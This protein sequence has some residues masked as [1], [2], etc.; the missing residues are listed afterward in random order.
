[1]EY[2]TDLVQQGYRIVLDTCSSV[3]GNTI[4][5]VS[6]TGVQAHGL[7]LQDALEAHQ[8]GRRHLARLAGPKG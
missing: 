6:G 1:M 7:T 5:V 3:E 4:F 8:R 2:L